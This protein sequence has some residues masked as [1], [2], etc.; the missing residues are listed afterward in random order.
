MYYTVYSLPKSL[1]RL[2][3]Y[4]ITVSGR[5][6]FKAEYRGTQAVHDVGTFVRYIL[7]TIP[8]G[9]AP[10]VYTFRATL[11]LGKVS[12]SRTWQFAVVRSSVLAKP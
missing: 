10:D 7:Y 3:T 6:V 11:T 5:S 9:L 12:K 2:T 4:D 1:T 8:H